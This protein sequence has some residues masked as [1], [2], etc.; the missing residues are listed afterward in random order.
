MAI[1]IQCWLLWLIAKNNFSSFCI[2]AS[3]SRASLVSNGLIT[4]YQN[5]RYTNTK[6]RSDESPT[7]LRNISFQPC[8]FPVSLHKPCQNKLEINRT[9]SRMQGRKELKQSCPY[10][11]TMW[12]FSHFSGCS[13]CISVT[14]TNGRND[15]LVVT[16]AFHVAQSLSSYS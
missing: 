2:A 15:V 12:S 9:C 10:A 8:C 14:V 6:T 7:R 5:I 1:R 4:W 13:R 16:K 11:S 3:K